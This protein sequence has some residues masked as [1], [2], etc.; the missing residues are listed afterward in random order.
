MC[1]RARHARISISIGTHGKLLAALP[2]ATQSPFTH[3]LSVRLGAPSLT[4]MMSSY[5]SSAIS[6]AASPVLGLT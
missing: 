6:D 5:T 1:M 3:A 2:K 4:A